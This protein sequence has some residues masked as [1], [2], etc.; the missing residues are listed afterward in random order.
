MI[1]LKLCIL[2]YVIIVVIFSQITCMVGF[3]FYIF[4]TLHEQIL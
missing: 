3:M 2:L 4:E 1:Y